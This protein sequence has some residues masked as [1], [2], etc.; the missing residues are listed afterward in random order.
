[1]TT[2]RSSNLALRHRRDVQWV[3]A[4]FVIQL[5][6][7]GLYFAVTTAR[8]TSLRYVLYP[9]VWTTVGVWAVVRTAS[10]SATVR[11]R[12]VGAGVAVAYLLVLGWIG[13]LV[14]LATAPPG[15]AGLDVIAASPGWGP[16]VVYTGSVFQF[17]LIPYLVVGYLAL[18]YLVYVAVAE[19]TGAALSGVVGLASCVSCSFPVLASLIAGVAGGSSGLTTAL[20]AFSIDLSTAAFLLAIGLLY[21]RPSFGG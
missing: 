2:T 21:W 7:I 6:L 11:A 9:V 16:A 13:G 1:M 15:Q 19:V 8:P 3:S 18:T 17:V 20:Y 14:D 5:V 12:S 10:P 4:L